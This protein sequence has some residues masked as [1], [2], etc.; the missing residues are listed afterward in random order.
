MLLSFCPSDSARSDYIAA[1]VEENVLG[2]TTG[3]TRRLS[4]QRLSELYA[5]DPSVPVFRALRRFWDNDNA[6]RPLLALLCSLARDPLLRSTLPSVIELSPGASLDREV[7]KESLRKTVKTRLNDSTL[8]KVARNAGSTWSQ[9]GHLEGRT[10][11]R[12]QS[13]LPTPAATAMALFLGYLQGIRG[14]GLLSSIWTRVLDTPPD[15]L[16]ELARRAATSGLLRYRRAG[17][18]IDVAFPALLTSKDL[19]VIHEQN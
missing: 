12:R 7:M 13:V 18:V 2:K 15:N 6:G 17:D 10:F 9:S 16:S 3:S 1:I 8:D 11:K 4:A 19:E 5:L 14:A